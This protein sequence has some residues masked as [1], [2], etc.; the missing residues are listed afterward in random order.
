MND[1]IDDR[2]NAVATTFMHAVVTTKK[3]IH[4]SLLL[5]L[6]FVCFF[7]YFFRSLLLYSLDCHEICGLANR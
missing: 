6:A 4:H 5:I 2:M 7:L 1:A 3:R